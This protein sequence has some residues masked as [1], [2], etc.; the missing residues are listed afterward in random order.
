M[1]GDA[2]ER[3]GE[4]RRGRRGEQHLKIERALGLVAV[5]GAVDPEDRTPSWAPCTTVIGISRTLPSMSVPIGM[6]PRTRVPGAA[7]TLR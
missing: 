4:R 1:D 6:P 7:V 2:D 3:A 5:G